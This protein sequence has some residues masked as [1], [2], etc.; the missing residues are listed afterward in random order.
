MGEV[1]GWWGTT[2]HRAVD[3]WPE[4][5]PE[6]CGRRI[7]ATRAL[8][9]PINRAPTEKQK[10]DALFERPPSLN[11]NRRAGILPA[12]NVNSSGGAKEPR[13]PLIALLSPPHRRV[14]RGN[15]VE[16]FKFT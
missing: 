9:D 4:P 15:R 1:R 14:E 6:V 7:H 5:Q 8:P 13:L 10:V 16:K 12:H 3:V 2:H 11:K